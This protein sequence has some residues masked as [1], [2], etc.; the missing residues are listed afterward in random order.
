MNVHRIWVIANNVFREVIRDRVLYL[1][2]V[3]ALAMLLAGRLIP[4]VASVASAKILQD[5]GL[6]AIA[7]IGLV[8]AVFVGAGLINKEIE[9]RTVLVLLAKPMG[10]SEFILGKHLGLCAVLAVLIATM[11]LINGLL[12]HS[13]QISFDLGAMAL[14]LVF[15]WLELCL[16]AAVALLFGAAMSSLLATLLTLAIFAMGHLSPD[17]VKL[18]A[19]TDNPE[20]QRAVRSLYLVLPDLSRLNLRNDAIYS[21]LPPAVTLGAIALYAL[22]Y[23]T[24]LLALSSVIFQRREF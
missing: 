24:A 7:L 9:K 1:I 14:S 17:L 15:L 16:V 8:V 22:L 6:G 13:Y 2:G 12:L 23:I 3:F 18:A 11:G 4:E 5:I 21:N 10:R 20:L 19:L